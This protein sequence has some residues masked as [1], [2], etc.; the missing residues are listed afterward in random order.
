MYPLYLENGDEV[1]KQLQEKKI[2]IPTLWP[3]VFN[4][5]KETDI[6]YDLAKNILPIP[7][8][9]RYGIEEME[10]MIEKIKELI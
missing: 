8:D 10:Y 6:E 1:R 2:F 9:Q 4:L 5:C 7:I 3:A